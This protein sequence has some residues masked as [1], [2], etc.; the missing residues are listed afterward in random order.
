MLACNKHLESQRKEA[1]RL[2][3]WRRELT[4][5]IL[6]SAEEDSKEIV[7]VVTDEEYEKMEKDHRE[8]VRQHHQDLARE[9][10]GKTPEEKK[11]EEE[12]F[13]TRLEELELEEE[14]QQAEEE[15]EKRKKQQEL[16]SVKP[17]E[18]DSQSPSKSRKP[19]VAKSVSFNN[20]PEVREIPTKSTKVTKSVSFNNTP[21][22][23][24]IPSVADISEDFDNFDDDF[25]PDE[26]PTVPTQEVAGISQKIVERAPPPPLLQDS[27][28]SAIPSSGFTES[29]GLLLNDEIPGPSAQSVKTPFDPREAAAP[30]KKASLFKQ[31]RNP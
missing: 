28:T 14:M 9:R 24:E 16:D 30:P 11:K 6:E 5:F 8:K 12:D 4:K 7:E 23:R 19:K 17:T 22:I 3:N 15:Y 26:L 1:E 18:P 21:E 25:G 29:L 31:R 27:S 10:V 20:T 2:E 13:W